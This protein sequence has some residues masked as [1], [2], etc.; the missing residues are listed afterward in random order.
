MT[1]KISEVNFNIT[2]N[3]IN[4]IFF[5]ALFAIGV[6]AIFFFWGQD[7]D[8]SSRIEHEVWGTFGD[9]VGGLIGTILALFSVVLM[10]TTFASQ[11]E[12][13]KQSERTQMQI[14]ADANR[15]HDKVEESNRFNSLFFEL[16][17]FYKSLCKDLDSYIEKKVDEYP[18]VDYFEFFR[19]SLYEGFKPGVNIGISRNLS[20]ESYLRFY[21]NESARI[22]PLFRTLYRII[23][24]IHNSKIDDKEKLR[25]VKI[26]RAQLNENELFMLRYNCMTPYGE[27][28]IEYVNLYRLLKHLPVLSLLEFKI[29]NERIMSLSNRHSPNFNLMIHMITRKI[30]RVTMNKEE[31]GIFDIFENSS[32]RFKLLLDL[33]DPKVT[34]IKLSINCNFKASPDLSV[35]SQFTDTE[36]RYF[37]IWTLREVYVYSNFGRFNDI[38]LLKFDRG[39]DQ[40]DSN[41]KEIWGKVEGQLPLRMCH[42]HWDSQ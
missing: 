18:V 36:I 6:T 14:A 20:R 3:S 9:F 12:L 16:L 33:Q 1:S 40:V 39:I 38:N 37:F 17:N 5:L 34:L 32:K 27:K 8:F 11:R 35:F 19:T 7:Y 42:K 4:W 26:I 2:K 23:D 29:F 28:F 21:A 25:Y 22:S 30:Y 41:I 10:Y 15:F 13:T 24:L 31:R